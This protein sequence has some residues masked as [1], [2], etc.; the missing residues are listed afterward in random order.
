MRV[1]GGRL[2]P[3]DAFGR[4]RLSALP[5]GTTLAVTFVRDRTHRHIAWYFSELARLW[6]TLPESEA[7]APWA[8]SPDTLRKHALISCGYCVSSAIVAD[9]EAQAERIM[10]S[11][12]SS[13]MATHGYALGTCHGCVATIYYPES[14]SYTAMGHE[15]FKA[16]VR[17]TLDWIVRKIGAEKGK[18]PVPVDS[19]A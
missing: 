13:G 3:C 17:D 8:A 12:V 16:S 14:Q 5:D 11:L 15:R 19:E 10:R 6:E 7:D 9:N 4:H 1:E 18:S 2:V